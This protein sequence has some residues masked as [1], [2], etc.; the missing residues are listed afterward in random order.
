MSSSS[1]D[2][3]EERPPPKPDW[4]T[5]EDTSARS[6]VFLVTFAAILDAT[7]LAAEVPLRSLDGLSRE[8]IKAAVLDAVEHPVQDAN[9]RGGRPRTATME[10]Q[11]LV[12]FLEEPRH[13][14]VALR[15]GAVSRFLPLKTALRRR[16]GLA[17]HWSTS[18]TQW[19]SAVRYGVFTTVHKPAVDQ[20]P[21]VWVKAL[22]V[23]EPLQAGPGAVQEYKDPAAGNVVVNLY[24]EAQQPFSSS[25][26]TKRRQQREAAAAGEAAAS[27][28]KPKAAKFTPLDFTALVLEK[29]LRTPSAVLAY[30]Q[31]HG[32]QAAQLYCLRNQKRLPELLTG[33]VQWQDAKRQ[34]ALELETDW[35]L[36]QRLAG[37]TCVCSGACKWATAASDFFRRN[38]ATVD[39][40]LVAATL[41][42]VI[43]HGPSKTARVPLIAG[44]TNAGK[45]LMLD[46]VINVFGPEAIDYC[47]A[48]GATMALSSLATNRR[49]RFIYWDEFSPTEFAAR[50]PKAPTLPAVTFKKLFAGQYFRVQVSQ[51]HHDGNPD[52]R[53]TRGAAMTAPLEGLWDV[54]GP[55]TREDVRHMQSRVV[56]FEA[57]V[58]IQGPLQAIP[59][60]AASWCKF[61]VEASAA[62]AARRPP[63]VQE[64]AIEDDD[65]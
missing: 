53:W 20:A 27:G 26:W 21:L 12:V 40:E 33:A 37:Q 15:L 10:A 42:Q 3:S 23:L 47:P 36:V 55:V 22:G 65:L 32:S 50:P 31:E 35:A 30:V 52:F 8:D 57:H 6:L 2:E 41:A 54:A 25:V 64:R 44:V 60:C 34:H 48:Q 51:A 46:P 49:L 43:C 58:S 14:H 38:H 59:H 28:R 19:W 16:A 5:D 62:Y 9:Q 17:S 29:N 39:S 61:V 4:F 7:A 63:Q 11:K 24:E 1:S 45:S 18:H 13:F 56:Q